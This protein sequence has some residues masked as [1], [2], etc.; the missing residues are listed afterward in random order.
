LGRK[1]YNEEYHESNV[2]NLDTNKAKYL[3][4]WKPKL[5]IDEAVKMAVE[6]YKNYYDKNIKKIIN[7]QIERFMG[8]I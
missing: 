7:D 8:D 5:N 1:I 2:L 4:G 6:W 3:L